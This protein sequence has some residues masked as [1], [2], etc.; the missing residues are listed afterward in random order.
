MA[1]SPNKPTFEKLHFLKDEDER[2]SKPEA[3]WKACCEW[4][5]LWNKDWG[6][7]EK[8]QERMIAFRKQRAINMVWV[9]NKL[10]GT[11]PEGISQ[12]QTYQILERMFDGCTSPSLEPKDSSSSQEPNNDRDSEKSRKS[13]LQITQHFEAFLYLDRCLQSEPKLLLS[14]DIIKT[15][16]RKLMHGLV[17][18]GSDNPVQ[19]GEYRTTSVHAGNH[20]F[21]AH[22][23]V[24]SAMKETIEEYNKQVLDAKHDPYA[25]AGWLLYRVVSIHPFMDGNGR[26][27]RLLWCF[28]LLRDGLPFPL[29][30]SSGYEKAHK[31]Y[32][33]CIE[34]D[35]RRSEKKRG[36]LA[37]LTVVSV[38]NAWENFI[39]NLE[40]EV[41]DEYKRIVEQLEKQPNEE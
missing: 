40:F 31:H 6:K 15:T 7:S 34:L 33:R 30:I 16:H 22:E 36:N 39:C 37:T 14:E 38:H 11:L 10:E 32:V 18:E 4:Q 28:S 25:L 8:L 21:P 29:T 41:P 19:A 26:L 23:I 20:T 13:Q 35:R 5:S 27:C 24:P 2:F 9:N 3:A 1:T 17:L 12:M